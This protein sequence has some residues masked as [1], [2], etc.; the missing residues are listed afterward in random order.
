MNLLFPIETLAR[1]LD[2]RLVLAALCARE[3]RS[4]FLGHARAIEAIVPLLRGGVYLGQKVLKAPPAKMTTLYALRKRQ[5]R[6]LF[7]HEEGG[8]FF[9]DLEG[10]RKKLLSQTDLANLTDEEAIF[11]WGEYQAACYGAYRP[12]MR[13]RIYVV[14]HPRFDLL[15]TEYRG[16]YD[17]EVAD[18]R[19]RYGKFILFNSSFGVSN[20]RDP[21]SFFFHHQRGFQPQAVATRRPMLF[22]W[23]HQARAQALLVEFVDRVAEHFPEHALILRPHPSEDETFYRTLLGAIPNVHITRA[24]GVQP[25]MIAAD[26]IVHENSTSGLE[27][28][29]GGRPVLRLAVPGDVVDQPLLTRDIGA[30]VYTLEDGLKRL[31]LLTATSA[32]PFE[33]QAD[34][35][36]TGPL[37]AN[38]NN[39]TFPVL[40]DRIEKELE[41]IAHRVSASTANNLLLAAALKST[42][43]LRGVG[44][45]AAGRAS[46]ATSTLDALRPEQRQRFPG[47]DP[48]RLAQRVARLSEML[49]KNLSIELLD[50]SLCVLRCGPANA[51]GG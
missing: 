38:V 16:L 49:G 1:E 46:L 21:L 32:V 30:P 33:R 37:L 22:A 4:I 40:V 8:V 9:G 41:D 5:I 28:A 26:V 23:A 25:W 10:V 24:G 2:Y 11:A 35:A 29:I 39:P 14:G 50:P 44:R 18:L 3:D 36:T 31:Q 48:V 13:H 6:Y 51:Q 42:A 19:K 12:D 15:R 27:A 45:A 20:G 17:E 7:H 34:A 43:L 47:F